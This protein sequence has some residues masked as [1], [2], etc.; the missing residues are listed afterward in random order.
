M[1]FHIENEVDND[2]AKNMDY[3]L[4]FNYESKEDIIF[5]VAEYH[6]SIQ[7][8]FIVVRS[9]K[10]RYNVKCASELCTFRLNYNINKN[11]SIV[12]KIRGLHTC[13]MFEHVEDNKGV[14]VNYL[15]NHPDVNQWFRTENRN[16]TTSSLKRYLNSIGIT[17]PYH[18][19]FRTL[20]ALQKKVFVADADQYKLIKD[21]MLEC[22]M[23]PNI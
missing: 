13:S 9:N 22:L 20:N 3:L 10:C 19:L 5:A 11:A 1:E 6:Y 7:R 23:K 8:E 18:T 2:P 15:V 16:A 21:Y 14:K 12:P 4:E 17:A